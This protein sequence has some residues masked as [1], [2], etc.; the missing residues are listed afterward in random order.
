MHMHVKD[1]CINT[2]CQISQPLNELG[3]EASLDGGEL[4]RQV[5]GHPG[6]GQGTKM[7]GGHDQSMTGPQQARTSRTGK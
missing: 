4:D 1:A 6:I 7:N 5:Q 3:F 2:K